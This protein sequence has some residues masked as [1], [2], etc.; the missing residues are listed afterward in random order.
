MQIVKMVF[1]SHLYGLNTESSDTDYKGIFMPTREQILLGKIPRTYSQNTGSHTTRNTKDDVD[2]ESFSLHEFVRLALTG[3]TI[4][5]DMLHA[6][7]EHIVSDSPIANVYE[8]MQ[9]YRTHFYSRDMKA[10]LGYVRRQASKY[11]VKGSRIAAANEVLDKLKYYEKL[12]AYVTVQD[13]YSKLPTGEYVRW[14]TQQERHMHSVPQHFYEVCGRK[15]QSTL[16]IT[17]AIEIV[18]KIIDGYGERA[19][20]AESN[21]G[22][23]WKAVSHALRAG[24]QLRD[25]Y[26]KG[27]FEYPL[28]ETSFLYNVKTGML[29]FK[30]QVQ[31]EL[32]NLVSEV[33]VLAQ[34]SKYPAKPDQRAW[35]EWLMKQSEQIVVNGLRVG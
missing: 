14:T 24:Y 17:Q 8:E 7:P 5:L 1:G 30:T 15:I 3:E 33:E 4:A 25:I 2:F 29:D 18:K 35:D 28:D 11:G 10:Y 26:K 21:E 9:K 22:I 32:E 31:P 20:M 19:K 23:D 16:S 6:K 27:D 34:N 13:I 12:D